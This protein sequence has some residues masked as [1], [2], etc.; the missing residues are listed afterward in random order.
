MY[1]VLVT[2]P[3]KRNNRIR[4]SPEKDIYDGQRDFLV[5][6]DPNKTNKTKT[7]IKRSIT[8]VHGVSKYGFG[9]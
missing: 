1:V 9:V 3:Q 4:E 5:V 6:T 8:G 2:A 7:H